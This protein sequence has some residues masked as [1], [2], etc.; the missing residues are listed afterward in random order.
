MINEDNSSSFDVNNT[1]FPI[2]LNQL[3]KK[4]NSIEETKNEYERA[5]I[6]EP[7]EKYKSQVVPLEKELFENLNLEWGVV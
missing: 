5:K 1:D 2:V 7:L 3:S 4:K 6:K